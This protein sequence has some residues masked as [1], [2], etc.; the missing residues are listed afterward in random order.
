MD[1]CNGNSSTTAAMDGVFLDF[2]GT[3]ASGDVQAV[4]AVCQQVIDD[5]GLVLT[6]SQM[7]GHWGQRFFAALEATNSSFKSLKQIENE[8]LIETLLPLTGRV[9]VKKYIRS[10]NTY[11]GRPTLYEEVQDVLA[12]LTVPVCIVSNADDEELCA[13]LEHHG[14]RFEYVVTSEGS[15]SYKPDRRIFEAAL[16]LTGWSPDRV[17]HVGDSLHSD[18]G[19]A[20]GVGLKAAWVNRTVRISDIG[21]DQPDYSWTDLRPLVDLTCGRFVCQ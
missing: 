21:T 19:G 20:H 8:T 12:A 13:A 11:L 10:F 2:Y 17:V 1:E 16:A 6:A 9:C 4:E 14:L 3:I 5:Y 15:Q 7:A 18:V